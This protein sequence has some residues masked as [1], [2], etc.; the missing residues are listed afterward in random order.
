MQ[1]SSPSPDSCTTCDEAD[2]FVVRG[3]VYEEATRDVD[4]FYEHKDESFGLHQLPNAEGDWASNYYRFK[5]IDSKK[6]ATAR[7]KHGF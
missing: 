3:T 1:E 5:I 2:V 4:M 6:L 7:L